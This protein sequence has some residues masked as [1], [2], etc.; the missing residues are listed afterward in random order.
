[1]DGSLEATVRIRLKARGR[2]EEIEVTGGEK[3]E[4]KGE[5]GSLPEKEF[6]I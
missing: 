4:S 1:M 5:I 2:R 3:G 6:R